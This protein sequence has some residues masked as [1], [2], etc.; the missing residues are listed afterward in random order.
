[1]ENVMVGRRVSSVWHQ[2]VD[3]EIVRWE[4][5][6]SSVSD[7]LVRSLDGRLCWYA[8]HGLVPVDDRGPLPTRSQAVE[9]RR[10]EMLAQLTAI[11]AQH[12]A[13]LYRERWVG[14]EF[15]KVL[16]GQM[17]EQALAELALD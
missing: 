1:M 3:G 16:V 5:F 4:P 11:R 7:V 15:G 12:L 13:T 9:Q 10:L 17:L 8:S 6:G 14:A 2:L